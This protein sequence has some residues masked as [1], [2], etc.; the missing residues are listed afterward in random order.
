MKTV[1]ADT[2]YWVAS[3][4]PR[5]QWHEAVLRAESALGDFQIITTESVLI[6]VLNF[7]AEYKQFLRQSA[8]RLVRSS[9]DNF[10]IEIVKHSYETFLAG[11][12]LYEAR[13]DKGYSVTD[14]ISMNLMRE[15]GVNEV[16][17]HDHHFEQEGFAVLL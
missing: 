5:D 8:A 16:L 17:T 7:Y 4:N 3:L 1:F 11:L 12:E 10:D 15:R 13:P 9:L 6:E 14:C 2:I